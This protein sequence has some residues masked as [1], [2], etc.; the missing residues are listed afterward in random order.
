VYRYTDDVVRDANDARASSLPGTAD[1]FT[2]NDFDRDGS[3]L[4]SYGTIGSYAFWL[5][6]FGPALALL[7]HQLHFS[8]TLL[9]VYSALWSSG[10]AVV[11]VVFAGV[12]RRRSRPALLWCSAVAASLGAALFTAP[13]GVALTLLGAAVLGFAGTTMLTLSQA[14]LSDRHGPRRDRALTEANIGAA[15]CA[16]GAPLLLGALQSGWRLAFALPPVVLA[17]LYL[18]YRHRPLP[19]PAGPAVTGRA[20]LS[21]ACWLLATLV[22]VGIVIYFGTQVLTATGLSTAQAATA[23]SSLYAGILVGRLGG[24]AITRRAGR[25]V[26]LLWISLA[27]TAGGFGMFWLSPNP[28]AAVTGLFL[29]GAGI[30]NLY[31][32]SLALTLGAAR[33]H[34]DLANARTQLLGGVLVI[35][36]PYLLG[37][38]ADHVGLHAAFGIEPV[39]IAVSA[40]LLLAGGRLALRESDAD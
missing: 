38:L 20:R 35:V 29:C 28:A 16:V 11:G 24:A 21:L 9:G 18:R 17:G 30:A 36:A 25:M 40:V 34:G 26:P 8:Y 7:Q 23:M 3:T 1:R 5:Y 2:E 13:G 19:A 27:L 33:Q 31:P 32:L 10:A 22:A 39:L 6:A 15:T 4:L 14:M 37:S 12:A